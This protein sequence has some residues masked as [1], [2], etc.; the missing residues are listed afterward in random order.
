MSDSAG[1]VP[2]RSPR[3]LDLFCCEGGAS[4]GYSRAGFEVVGVDIEDRSRG[5][6]FEFHQADALE[7]VAAHGHEF[8]A[9]AASPPCQR[10]SRSA[11]ATKR[12][13]EHPDLIEPTR[14]ALIATGKPYIIENVPEAPLIAPV[15]ICGWAMGL[16]HIKRHRHFESNVWLMSP[17][18]ACPP[19]DTVSVFG[20][21]GEDR[22]KST[23]A[24]RGGLRGHVPLAEVKQLMGVEWMVTRDAVSESI[25]PAYTEYLGAQLLAHMTEVAA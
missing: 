14:A 6:P 5:Y 21:S 17:G 23:L 18:C 24:A 2:S 7:F 9:I 15:M 19:G 25:P 11:S 4:V 13:H 22:R 12:G 10:F 16:H 1:R 20:H 8:D 3:L